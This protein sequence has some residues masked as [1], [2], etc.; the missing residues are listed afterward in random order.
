MSILTK[1]GDHA[2]KLADAVRIELLDLLN[3]RKCCLGELGDSCKSQEV[4]VSSKRNPLQVAN[5]KSN[6]GRTYLPGNA[7]SRYVL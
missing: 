6:L 5:G 4:E 7:I 3:R 2:D 1:D